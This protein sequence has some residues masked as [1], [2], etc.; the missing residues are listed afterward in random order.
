LS[1]GIDLPPGMQ[2]ETQILFGV[3]GVS[4]LLTLIS[5]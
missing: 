2:T 4:F 1:R 3:V 5:T